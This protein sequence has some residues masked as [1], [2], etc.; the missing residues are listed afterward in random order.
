[1][2]SSHSLSTSA[3]ITLASHQSAS[4]RKDFS[5][6]MSIHLE[7]F[8][9]QSSMRTMWVP[10]AAFEKK[11]GVMLVWLMSSVYLIQRLLSALL[12][13]V[14]VET[15]HHSEANSCR[16]PR[17]VGPAKSCRSCTNRRLSSLHSGMCKFISILVIY[18]KPWCNLNRKMTKPCTIGR[19]LSLCFARC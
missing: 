1:M 17:L 10:S 19:I 8:V 12:S 16:Y 2:V 14:G 4:F 9:Y 3:K 15:S 7:L 11:I 5:T 13:F 6:L 18:L